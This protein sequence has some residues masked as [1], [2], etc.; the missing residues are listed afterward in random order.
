MGVW[1]ILKSPVWIITPASVR[2]ANA[3]ASIT[4]CVILIH[5]T[6]NAPILMGLRFSTI[7][8][9]ER[10]FFKPCS[11]NLLPIIPSGKGVP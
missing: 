2:I 8:K 3:E 5:S 4:E 7:L 1:S 6:S 9:N 11:S 10:Y